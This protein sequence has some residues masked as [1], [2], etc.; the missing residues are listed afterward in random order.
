[1]SNQ[2]NAKNPPLMANKDMVEYR[3][4]LTEYQFWDM[5]D[6]INWA[7]IS[8]NIAE[9]NKD[10]HKFRMLQK[11]SLDE[12]VAMFEKHKTKYE[13]L[14]T[15]LWTVYPP[16]KGGLGLGDDGTWDLCA[17]IV[18]LGKDEYLSTFKDPVRALKRA[19]TKD[20]TECFSYW[21]PRDGDYNL[22]NSMDL[23]Y[24]IDRE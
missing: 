11:Y 1:M 12:W 9:I 6:A 22:P 17:H 2:I 19:E 7:S 14:R 13:A 15:Y 3:I 23:V 21:I 10:I 8:I 16:D 18:G 5:V 4:K 24:K 20:F